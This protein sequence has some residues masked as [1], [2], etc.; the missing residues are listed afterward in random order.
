MGETITVPYSIS[1]YLNG[2]KVEKIINEI[3][4]RYEGKITMDS[5]SD[6]CSGY[7]K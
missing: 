5:D 7:G 6:T 1:I 4:F 3:T 2:E